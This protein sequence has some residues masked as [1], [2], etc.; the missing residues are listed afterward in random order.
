MNGSIGEEDKGIGERVGKGKQIDRGGV[1]EGRGIKEER[2]RW[3]EEEWERRYAL[4]S[5]AGLCQV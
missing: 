4:C 1:R 3:R 2:E 5:V